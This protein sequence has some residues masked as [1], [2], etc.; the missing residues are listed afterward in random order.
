MKIL[1]NSVIT[2]GYGYNKKNLPHEMINFFRADDNNYYVYITPYGVIDKQLNIED[3]RAVLFVRSTGDGLVEILA[4]AEIDE[5]SILYTKGIQLHGT[6]GT[7]VM[8]I[9]QIKTDTNAQQKRKEEYIESIKHIKYGNKSLG[10]IHKDNAEDNDVLVTLKAKSICL[11]K[12]TMY[13]THIQS[14]VALRPSAHVYYIG[15]ELK[16]NSK[17]ANQSMKR[18][19]DKKEQPGAYNKLQE[20]INNAVLWLS[21]DETPKYTS[22]ILEDKRNFFKVTRQQDNEVMFSNM[23]FYL[24]NEYHE[25]LRKF[26]FEVLKIS[27][28]P[29]ATIEREKERMDIRV[30]DDNNYI[31]IENKIKSGINGMIK[32]DNEFETENDKYIS[33]L[34]VYYKRAQAKNVA[35]NK[36]RKISGFIFTPN[37]NPIETEKYLFG[38]K[39]VIKTYKELYDFFIKYISNPEHEGS[40]DLYL[41]DFVMAMEKH[42]QETDNEFRDELMSRL[43]YRINN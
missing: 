4:K 35:D 20:I 11:P 28:S 34:S 12:R 21:P 13:L 42:T 29:N 23:F 5:N 32:T 25:L 26:A 38:E 14:S 31:I 1:V 18:Y 39:Y 9:K 40:E 17:L 33:Q 27:V 15:Q 7:D 10:E 19:F 43:A 30:I 6:K 24:F 36:Q 3:L 8:K 37:H 22:S 41:K 2:G 16:D